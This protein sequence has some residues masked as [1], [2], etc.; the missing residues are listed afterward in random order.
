MFDFNML[1][2]FVVAV[3]GTGKVHLL[4]VF[5]ESDHIWLANE[6]VMV[7]NYRQGKDGCWNIGSGPC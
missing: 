3:A 5:G 2:L 4:S 7:K 6:R 1:R